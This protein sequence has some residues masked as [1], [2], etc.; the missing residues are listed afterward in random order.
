MGTRDKQFFFKIKTEFERANLGSR[1]T[2]E[3]IAGVMGINPKTFSS[4]LIDG[5]TNQ[6]SLDK[7]SRAIPETKSSS[8]SCL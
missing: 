7:W 8:Q 1:L 6:I 2:Q 5:G 3:N 4:W